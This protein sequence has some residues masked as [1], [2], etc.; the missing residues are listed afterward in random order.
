MNLD[1]LFGFSTAIPAPA[2]RSQSIRTTTLCAVLLALLIP[3]RGFSQDP[4]AELLEAAK[5]GDLDAVKSILG[6][7]GNVNAKGTNG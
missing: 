2:R 4:S 3:L 1:R 5:K 6:K 7:G